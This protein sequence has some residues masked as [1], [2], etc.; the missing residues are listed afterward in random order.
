[1]LSGRSWPLFLM[2]AL[3]LFLLCCCFAASVT[4]LV[5]NPPVQNGGTVTVAAPEKTPNVTILCEV[6][7]ANSMTIGTTWIHVNPTRQLISANNPLFDILPFPFANLTIRLFV[8]SLDET[9]LECSNQVSPLQMVFF[10]LKII[11]KT[12]I[13]NKMF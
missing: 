1:M 5:T 8:Q 6:T 10:A 9:T 11:S 12:M 3:D 13:N 4:A 2:T 7:D